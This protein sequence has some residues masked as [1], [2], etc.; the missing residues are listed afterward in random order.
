MLD[1]KVEK[2]QQRSR[3]TETNRD[4]HT[5]LKEQAAQIQK[6]SAQ[7]EMVRPTPRVV[8][9]DKTVIRSVVR[10][11]SVSSIQIQPPRETRAAAVLLYC[12]RFAVRSADPHAHGTRRLSQRGGYS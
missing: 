3:S 4:S 8:R 6:V 9:I 10:E 1:Q 12:S 2:L 7:L 11:V 5:Q